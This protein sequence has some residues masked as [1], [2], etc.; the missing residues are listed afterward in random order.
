MQVIFTARQ[1]LGNRSYAKGKQEVPD[2]LAYNSA[3]K[4][5]VVSGAVQ[6]VPRDA[7]AQKVQDGRD[8]QAQK[9]AQAAR[10]ARKASHTQ[11]PAQGASSAAPKLSEV[12]RPAQ[13]VHTP[14][15]PAIAGAA[16]KAAPASAKG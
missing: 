3:F 5:L 2:S 7:V 8:L 12:P 6:V 11:M 14:A 13:A 9:D 16:P 1:V 4:K 10:A 15:Q